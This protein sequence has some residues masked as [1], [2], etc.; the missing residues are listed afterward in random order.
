A[1][2]QDDAAPALDA[3]VEAGRPGPH[4]KILQVLEGRFEAS[5]HIWMAPGDPPLSTRGTIERTSVFDGR[6]LRESV[7]TADE[8]IGAFEGLGFIGYDNAEGRYVNVWMDSMST[9][10]ALEYATYDVGQRTFRFVGMHRDPATGRVV[11][12]RSTFDVSNP[13]RQIL[14]SYAT[15]PDGAEYKSFEGVA[16]RIR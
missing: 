3:A 14:T 10:I 1:S 11:H 4:H 9:G 13:D 7:R 16:E 8:G 6:Y 5:F 15:G 2:A 12:T